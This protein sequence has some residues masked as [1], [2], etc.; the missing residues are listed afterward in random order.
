MVLLGLTVPSTIFT[1]TTILTAIG[2]VSS[3]T[4]EVLNVASIL[5]CLALVAISLSSGI[6]GIPKI[7]KTS[8]II[9]VIAPVLVVLTIELF[10]T[11]TVV[12]KVAQVRLTGGLDIIGLYDRARDAHLPVSVTVSHDKTIIWT[13]IGMEAEARVV[14]AQYLENSPATK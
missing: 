12:N 5:S 14:Y 1:K 6:I 13:P 10:L 9:A 8:L 7:G 3:A 11:L 4:V 2:V